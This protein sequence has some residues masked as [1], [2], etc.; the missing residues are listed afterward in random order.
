LSV[1]LTPGQAI[2]TSVVVVENVVLGNVSWQIVCAITLP[3]H[4]VVF[5]MIIPFKND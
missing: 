3:R 1:D 4:I 5:D 2:V